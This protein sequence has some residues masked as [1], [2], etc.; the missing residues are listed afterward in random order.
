[1]IVII[2]YDSDYLV[3]MENIPPHIYYV[4]LADSAW[5]HSIKLQDFILK[6]K[7]KKKLSLFFLY[8]M[9]L[10]YVCFKLNHIDSYKVSICSKSLCCYNLLRL[11]GL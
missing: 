2:W 9:V 3:W 11:A 7:K 8:Y 5:F 1:M 10:H 4:L 6:K